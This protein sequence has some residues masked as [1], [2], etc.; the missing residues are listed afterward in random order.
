MANRFLP[1]L[2]AVLFLTGCGSNGQ[3][4]LSPHSKAAGEIAM[5]WWVMFVGAWI[6][7]GVVVMLL[8]IAVLR[9]RTAGRASDAGSKRL[10]L[11]GGVVAPIVVLSALFGLAV[12]TLPATSAPKGH[13][14][15][16]VLVIGHQWFWEVR[17]PGTAAVTANEIHIPARTP[18]RL[19]VRTA[20]VIHSFWVPELNRKIDLI[21]GRTNSI[22]LRADRPGRYRGQCAEFCGLQ[23][24]NMAFEVVAEPAARFRRWLAAQ[25]RPAAPR[26]SGEQA[27]LGVGCAAC[28]TIR[29]TPAEGDVGPDL[30]HV[31]SRTTLAALTIPNNRASLA[32][33]IADPQHVK[34]GNKMPR[35]DLGRPE[36]QAVVAYLESLK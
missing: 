25:A 15:R 10:I 27:F 2:G 8:A 21:P 20:D 32:A 31:A 36:L 28:H 16:T 30:T 29:G 19:E 17:Y 18:V 6:V 9:R 23:H 14:V 35:L 24:A 34:P 26:G 11:L 4:T 1:L 3:S 13:A 33:W 22:L 12:R 5:L 7:F